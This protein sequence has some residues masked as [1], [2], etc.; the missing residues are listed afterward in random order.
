VANEEAIGALEITL[1]SSSKF[2]DKMDDANILK[3]NDG[4]YLIMMKSFF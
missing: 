3:I 4:I 1:H 2:G